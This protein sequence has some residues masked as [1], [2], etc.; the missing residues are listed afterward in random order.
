[1][2]ASPQSHDT[3][4]IGGPGSLINESNGME[5]SSGLYSYSKTYYPAVVYF[6]YQFDDKCGMTNDTREGMTVYELRCPLR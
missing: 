2:L 3:N 1:M 6:R 5:I 4:F